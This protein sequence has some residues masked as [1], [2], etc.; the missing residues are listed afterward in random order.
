MSKSAEDQIASTL[1]PCAVACDGFGLALIQR[2][3]EPRQLIESHPIGFT[4]LTHPQSNDACA[5][6]AILCYD[7]IECKSRSVAFNRMNFRGGVG[8][9]G[10]PWLQTERFDS[11]LSS[12]LIDCDVLRDC[13]EHLFCMV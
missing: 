12:G 13:N 9:I 3:I 2:F 1:S 7:L 11:L 8:C 10:R 5:Q 6:G 4:H